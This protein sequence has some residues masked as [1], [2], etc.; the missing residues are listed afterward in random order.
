MHLSTSNAAMRACAI[1]FFSTLPFAAP[2]QDADFA[3]NSRVQGRFGSNWDHCTVIG[4]R[5]PTGGYLLRCDARPEQDFV[6]AASDVRAMQ[7]DDQA[8][9]RKSPVNR[10]TPASAPVVAIADEA[11]KSIPPRVGVYGCMDQDGNDAPGVQFGIIDG[12]TYTTY[13]GGGGKYT[14]SAQSGELVF[15]TGPYVG[16]RHSRQ[17]ERSFRMLDEHGALTAFNCPWGPKDPHKF[18]W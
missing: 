7:G 13:E 10:I 15:T 11:F 6:F 8:P 1:V 9:I 4:D 18:H 17:S 14:Y 12:S 5:R 3:A 16:I 2:A